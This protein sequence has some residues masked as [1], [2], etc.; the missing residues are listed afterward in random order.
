M[1]QN[2]IKDFSSQLKK[3]AD[4]FK[5]QLMG[6]RTNRATSGLVEDILVDYYG[7]KTAIK[8]LANVSIIQPNGISIQ[9]YDPTSLDSI[10]K[11]IQ[12]SPLGV[13]PIKDNNLARI[14][15]PP[16]TEERRKELTKLVSQ[17]QEEFKVIVKKEREVAIE[18]I[19]KAFDAKEIPE[20]DKFRRKEEIQKRVDETNKLIEQLTEEKT[21][22]IMSL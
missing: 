17:K 6:V 16:L 3:L 12:A 22:E 5:N 8:A 9:P 19:N 7:V 1:D 21:K 11:A 10:V 2:F 18:A 15:L 14:T 20:D 13:Q 4:D